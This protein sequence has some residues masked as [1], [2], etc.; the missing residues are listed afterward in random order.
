MNKVKQILEVDL[1]EKILESVK[2]RTAEEG[3]KAGVP[4]SLIHKDLDNW[5]VLA[6][7][8]KVGREISH[9]VETEL[10]FVMKTY[11]ENYYH[12]KK[13]KIL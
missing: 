3:N 1:G 5:G 8:D 9:L 10:L 11:P 4:E 6:S 7:E 2:M 12:Y 13:R